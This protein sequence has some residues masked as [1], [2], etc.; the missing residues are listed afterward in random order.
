MSE[1]LQSMA[2]STYVA[3][4]RTIEFEKMSEYVEKLSEKINSMEKIGHRIQKERIGMSTYVKLFNILAGFV[5]IQYIYI[6]F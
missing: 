3:K 1:S 4:G 5:I 6:F 2:S